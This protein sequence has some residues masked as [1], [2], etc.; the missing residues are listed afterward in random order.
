MHVDAHEDE[1]CEMVVCYK[2]LQLFI[3]CEMLMGCVVDCE[4]V[5]VEKWQQRQCKIRY[6]GVVS[7]LFD[8]GSIPVCV[9]AF[10]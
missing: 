5:L 10:I 3:G 9:F 1:L 2:V 7:T 8:C 6:R 4:Y